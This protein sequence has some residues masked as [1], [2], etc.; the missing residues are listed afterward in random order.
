MIGEVLGGYKV[1]SKLGEGATGETYLA[2]HQE[3][4]QKAAAKVLFPPMSADRALLDRF[5]AEVRAS[6]Q[7]NHVG[8]ADLYDCGVHGSGRAYLVMELLQGKTLT[9]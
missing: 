5:F 1:V 4:G 3:T 9:D 6:S 7:V 2:E 8:I